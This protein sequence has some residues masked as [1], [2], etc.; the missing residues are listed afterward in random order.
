MIINKVIIFISLIGS[1]VGLSSEVIQLVDFKNDQIIS[2]FIQN[3]DSIKS[4]M[5]FSK[6]FS[7]QKELT[8]IYDS[9]QPKANIGIKPSPEEA[10]K[11]FNEILSE[12]KMPFDYTDEGCHARAHMISH[13][14]SKKGISTGK[15]W[16][17]GD[18]IDPAQPEQ[19]W[20]YHVSAIVYVEVD[21]KTEVRVIDP[22]PLVK[23]PLTVEEWLKI[24][25]VDEYKEISYPLPEDSSMYKFVLAYSSP[26][27]YNISWFDVG[28]NTNDSGGETKYDP[29]FWRRMAKS[30]NHNIE[31]ISAINSN[32]ID[33][34]KRVL[35]GAICKILRR[36]KHKK[37]Q[38]NSIR[39]KYT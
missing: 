22:S 4:S 37:T 6:A 10:L 34:A 27:P 12:K 30:I 16:V 5:R 28:I 25:N 20:G 11:Y 18:L 14:F 36:E 2:N 38:K 1:C 13:W 3:N 31:L 33:R 19:N 24:L 23:R 17:K 21:G 8:E 29:K 39:T 9:L 32:D 7:S 15:I 35:E 26:L